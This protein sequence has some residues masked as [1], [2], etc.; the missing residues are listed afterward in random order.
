[1]QYLLKR[2]AIDELVVDWEKSYDKTEVKEP[3]PHYIAR[4]QAIY[5]LGILIDKG[6][7]VEDAKE[8]L[9]NILQ[10]GGLGC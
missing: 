6:F 4:K 7:D 5:L 9:R 8:G 2:K 1:M 3:L 10:N